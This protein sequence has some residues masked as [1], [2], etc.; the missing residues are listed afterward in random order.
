VVET[1]VRR[2]SANNLGDVVE[3]LEKTFLVKI[4]D[5]FCNAF[6]DFIKS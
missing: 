2:D 5:L 6:S 4:E 1:V 3:S